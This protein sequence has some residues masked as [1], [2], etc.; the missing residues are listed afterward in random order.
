M[1]TR[2]FTVEEANSLLPEIE[3]LVGELLER[4]ARVVRTRDQVE[5]IL[6]DPHSNMGSA[7][8]TRMA[9]EFATIEQLVERIQAYGCYL[10]DMNAGLVDF[11][12]ERDGREVFLCWRYGESSIHYYHELHTGYN[13]R[14][15][16]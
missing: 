10:K 14:Q 9:Q 16:V 12:S 4:R 6:E 1:S 8:A 11:L 13:G 3:P 15:P 2:Y 7:A 5:G